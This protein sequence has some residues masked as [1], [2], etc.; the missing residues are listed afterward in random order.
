MI[1]DEVAHRLIKQVTL[2]LRDSKGFVQ[3]DSIPCQVGNNLFSIEL[4]ELITARQ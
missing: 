1:I 4:V 2:E 3:I